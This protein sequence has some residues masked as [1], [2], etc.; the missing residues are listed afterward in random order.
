[1]FKHLCRS[2]IGLEPK[3]TRSVRH[4]K[5]SLWSKVFELALVATYDT[6]TT[7]RALWPQSLGECLVDEPIESTKRLEYSEHVVELL[8]P[9]ENFNFFLWRLEHR[10][11]PIIY[12]IMESL[13]I[14]KPYEHM[15][16]YSKLQNKCK[17][18]HMIP[19]TKRKHKYKYEINYQNHPKG[20]TTTFSFVSAYQL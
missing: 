13:R 3:A 18:E 14:P 8:R 6:L 11:P 10:H 7:E 15:Y 20:N 9:L 19:Q 16:V 2:S 12:T 4:R 17:C 1:V 5:G